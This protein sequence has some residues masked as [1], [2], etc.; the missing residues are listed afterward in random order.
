MIQ[1]GSERQHVT[2]HLVQNLLRWPTVFRR[3]QLQTVL[4]DL[5]ELTVP[6]FGGV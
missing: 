5:A 1:P 3:R 2:H 4:Q 6:G